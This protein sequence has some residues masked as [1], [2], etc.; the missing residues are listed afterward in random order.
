MTQVQ[1]RILLALGS[2]VGVV[3]LLTAA[4]LGFGSAGA[5]PRQDAKVRQ[6]SQGAPPVSSASPTPAPQVTVRTTDVTNVR[7]GPGTNYERVTQLQPGQSVRAVARNQEGTW[8]LLD[9]ETEDG[10]DAWV[11]AEVVEVSG[12]VS[13]LPVRGGGNGNGNGGSGTSSGGS[14]SGG[15]ADLFVAGASV[16]GQGTVVVLVGN[17]GPGPASGSLTVRIQPAGGAAHEETVTVT[18]PAQELRAVTTGYRVARSTQA[19]VTLDPAGALDTV[20]PANNSAQVE[21]LTP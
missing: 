13:A 17:L 15:R 2:A 5:N 11:S 6:G 16:N 12:D 14:A 7:S 19:V 21:L 3:A 4:V 10:G 9:L 18:I 8:L 1:G 20:N